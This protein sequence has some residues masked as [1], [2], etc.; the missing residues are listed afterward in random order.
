MLTARKITTVV[1][2]Q[3]G[4]L[5]EAKCSLEHSLSPQAFRR[6]NDPPDNRAN[7]MWLGSAEALQQLGL[8]RG[9]ETT[10]KQLASV[11]QG[12]HAIT[13]TQ[14]RRPDSMSSLD[15]DNQPRSDQQCTPM[16]QS[17]VNSF[18]LTFWTP[19]SIGWV[20]SQTNAELRAQLEHA[21]VEGANSTLEHL[22]QT[23]PV[24]G[25]KEPAQGFAA[26]VVL[27]MRAR[28]VRGEAIPPPL[29]HVH[30][31][32]V[33]VLDSNRILRTPND[34]AMYEDNAMRECGAVGRCELADKLVSLGF[35]IQPGTGRDGRYFEIVGVPQGLVRSDAWEH[36]ECG[37]LGQEARDG[38]WRSPRLG[39]AIAMT[40]APEQDWHTLFRQRRELTRVRDKALQELHITNMY[41]KEGRRTDDDLTDAIER[42]QQTC[43][44][45]TAFD[46]VNPH[47]VGEDEE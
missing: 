19:Q 21:T 39:H 42:A 23:R 4:A 40:S 37:R 8:K 31:Y 13:E 16:R 43:E 28:K 11:L 17:V 6:A 41:V 20:W 1:D 5:A 14:V 35:Q 3:R 7:S 15:M 12:R 36:A 46:T 26:S 9:A 18:E 22:T 30:C 24:V 27:H 45:V 47:M 29:L 25:G 38:D 10:A 32:L 44:A 2:D 33:G 34:E